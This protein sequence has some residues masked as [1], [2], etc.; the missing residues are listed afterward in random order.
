MIFLCF[1]FYFILL[2]FFIV[3]GYLLIFSSLVFISLNIVGEVI[4]GFKQKSDRFQFMNPAHNSVQRDSV[5]FCFPLLFW[6]R[7]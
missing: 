2:N 6:G 4:K 5:L 7:K 3:S 1:N